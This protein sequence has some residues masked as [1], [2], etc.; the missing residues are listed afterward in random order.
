MSRAEKEENP[1]PSAGVRGNS[2]LEDDGEEDCE[3]GNGDGYG[4]PH[5]VASPTA[6]RMF[7]HGKDWTA[8][9]EL[10]EGGV[11]APLGIYDPAHSQVAYSRTAAASALGG[12]GV[13]DACSMAAEGGVGGMGLRGATSTRPIFDQRGVVAMSSAEQMTD[14]HGQRRGRFE[15]ASSLSPNR[16]RAEDMRREEH[17]LE[18]AHRGIEHPD[19]DQAASNTSSLPPVPAMGG[20]GGGDTEQHKPFVRPPLGHGPGSQR[21]M[22][23]KSPRSGNP[24]T[25]QT[26]CPHLYYWEPEALEANP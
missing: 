20:G 4:A 6:P 14:Y 18:A 9:W 10:E 16:G 21:R 8:P 3:E 22:L 26:S 23:Q 13:A 15:V 17:R 12:M 25:S 2:W 11:D 1:L 24:E 5:D 19:Q 7:M